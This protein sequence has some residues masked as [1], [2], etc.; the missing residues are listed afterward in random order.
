[1]KE[2]VET[3]ARA[4]VHRPAMVILDEATSALDSANET[5][6]Y[7]RLRAS[8][9]TL[10]S[11]AHRSAVLTHH[12]HV[13]QLQGGG[14][15]KLC[16]AKDFNFEPAL[17]AQANGPASGPVNGQTSANH[18]GGAAAA[19]GAAAGANSSTPVV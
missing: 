5:S 16:A 11:I 18:G 6:L 9:A 2:L 12:T 15:W 19:T 14:G 17:E 8:G 10:V 4:L 1:M 7:Q 13:L 3:I